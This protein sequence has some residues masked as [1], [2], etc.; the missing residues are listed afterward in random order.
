M[1]KTAKFFINVSS[2]FIVIIFSIGCI[3]HASVDTDHDGYTDDVDDYPTDSNFHKNV[4]IWDPGVLNLEEGQGADKN[5][6]VKSDLKVIVV[7][8][9]V[10]YPLNL[11]KLEQ[12][13]ITFEILPPGVDSNATRYYYDETGDRNLRLSVNDSN[14]GNWSFSFYN[15]LDSNVENLTVYKEIYGME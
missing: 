6:N 7:N 13:N 12:H 1:K 10:L 11:S 9:S 3:S 15:P 8:W 5:Y 2:I 4:S 14:W